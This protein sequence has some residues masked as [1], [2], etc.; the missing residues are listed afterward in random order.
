MK[1]GNRKL[2]RLDGLACR[3]IN[4]PGFVDEPANRQERR[5]NARLERQLRKRAD[6]TARAEV[7]DK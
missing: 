7:D 4:K 6:L 5:A 2:K 3:V 1:M